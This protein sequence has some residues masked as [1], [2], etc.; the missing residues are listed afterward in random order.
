LWFDGRLFCHIKDF[1]ELF[2]VEI[3][4]KLYGYGIKGYSFYDRSGDDYFLN[5]TIPIEIIRENYSI[6]KEL[7]KPIVL[8]EGVEETL[9]AF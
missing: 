4:L 1:Y 3:N 6:R 7:L 8:L 2:K 9:E 5:N